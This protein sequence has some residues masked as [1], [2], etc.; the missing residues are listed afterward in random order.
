ME[1]SRLAVSGQLPHTSKPA[2]VTCLWSSLMMTRPWWY[3]E[4][5]DTQGTAPR[6]KTKKLTRANNAQAPLSAL[7]FKVVADTCAQGREDYEARL[8]LIRPDQYVAWASDSA[9]SD[10]REILCKAAG[11]V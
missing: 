4:K 6:D 8:I 2:K 10:A 5:P 3:V 1:G 9:A 11:L 7:V